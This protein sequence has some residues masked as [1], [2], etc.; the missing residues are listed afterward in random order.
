MTIGDE[1]LDRHLRTLREEAKESTLTFRCPEC[2]ATVSLSRW[3]P[4]YG[5]PNCETC[6]P[7]IRM[8]L[9]Q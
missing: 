7:Y 8:E 9:V 5:H 2:E 4:G 6:P 3:N 1:R